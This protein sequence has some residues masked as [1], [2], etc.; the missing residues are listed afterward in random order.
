[1]HVHG[2][3]SLLGI[4]YSWAKSGFR[5]RAYVIRVLILLCLIYSVLYWE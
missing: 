1:M 4:S 5:I 2:I 3:L